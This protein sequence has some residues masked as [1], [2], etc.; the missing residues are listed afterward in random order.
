MSA[1][2]R[3]APRVGLVLGAGGP[4]GH[5]FHA[6]ALHALESALGW[7]P[8]DADLILGTSAGA[9]VAALVRAGMSGADLAARAS[10]APLDARAS[11]IARH[12]VRPSTATPDPHLPARARPASLRFVRDALR[13]PRRLRPGRLA[14]ALL[15]EGRVRL[16]PQADGLRRLFGQA[17]PERETW[18]TAVHLDS[19]ER[20]AFGA[21]G[22]PAIDVGTAV[23]CSSAVPS[24][25]RPVEWR[26]LRYV[27]GGMASATHLDLLHDRELDLV[28][29]SSPLS[30]FTTMRALFAWERR[31]LERRVPVLALE[32]VDEAAQAMGRRPMDTARA[33]SVVHAA[34]TA[35]E[36]AL[37]HPRARALLRRLG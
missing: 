14:A 19:G 6:G 26:G 32:P 35:V 9:Q 7:D 13:E 30:M 27:D 34:K 3:R 11:A 4:V 8:R 36:R 20:V 29:V 24:V 22:A 23:S 33:P 17:W 18:I 28:I 37:R 25:F 10:G 15:P 31:Q 2:S 5:A 12:F 1:S 21:P 16:D